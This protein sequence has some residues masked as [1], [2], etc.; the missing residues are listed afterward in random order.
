MYLYECDV[1]NKAIGCDTYLVS[2]EN[3]F[4]AMDSLRERLEEENPY[5]LSHWVILTITRKD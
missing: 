2:A 5:P 1:Y 4:K 3:E